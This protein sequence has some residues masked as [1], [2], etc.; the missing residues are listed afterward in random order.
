MAKIFAPSVRY[1]NFTIDVVYDDSKEDYSGEA[2]QLSLKNNI[3]TAINDFFSQMGINVALY[4]SD[5]Y[6]FILRNVNDIYGVQMTWTDSVTPTVVDN[7]YD[8]SY[9][10]DNDVILDSPKR[11]TGYKENATIVIQAGNDINTD[12]ITLLRRSIYK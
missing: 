3:L 5:F 6:S 12:A 8:G 4:I 1:V 9:T 7:D 2:G 11:I 10:H